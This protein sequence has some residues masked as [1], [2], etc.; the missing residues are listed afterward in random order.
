MEIKVYGKP[1]M[2]KFVVLDGKEF[3]L[4]KVYVSLEQIMNTKENDSCYGDYSLRDYQ[5]ISQ[6][7]MDQLVNMG[8]VKNYPGPRMANL[9]CMKDEKGIEKL[10]HILY[11]LDM[12]TDMPSKDVR[13]VIHGKWIEHEF[14]S[15]IPYQEDENGDV[16]M[17]KYISYKCNLC[18]RTESKQ[19]PY[20]N[21][22]AK[23]NLE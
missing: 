8:L 4:S 11:E 18:G 6:E 5:L 7:V 12:R 21:C 22:G 1:V 20:C 9:Y 17:H 2:T 10:Q 23:M 19:E 3:E 13:E 14:E 15:I 16:V